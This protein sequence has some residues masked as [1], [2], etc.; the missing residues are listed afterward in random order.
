[1]PE[2]DVMDFSTL[3]TEV[4]TSL[5]AIKKDVLQT[6]ADERKTNE[7]LLK[8]KADGKAFSE[9]EEKLVKLEKAHDE[10]Q[11]AF[12]KE[13]TNLKISQSSGDGVDENEEVKHA[14]FEVLRLGNDRGLPDNQ[15]EKL[16]DVLTKHYNA[17]N[18]QH[19]SVEQIKAMLAGIDTTGG[20]LV[21]PP[22]LEKSIL[23]G[24]EENRALY[25]LASKTRISSPVYKRDARISEAGASWEGEPERV[26]PETSTPTYGQIE[27]AV[28][29]LI[30][31]PVVSR[32]LIEDARIDMEAEVM[33]FVRRA[34]DAK[35]GR[36]LIYGN[37]PRQPRGLLTYDTIAETKVKEDE[38]LFGK[39]GFVKTGNASG[40]DATA[41]IDAL[42]D[43]QTILK[44]GYGNRAAWLMNRKTGATIRKLK[45]TEGNYVWQP[46]LVNG[47]PA[48]IL[49]NPVYYDE[50]MPDI[51]ANAYP[52]AYGDFGEAMLVVNRRG[53][54]VIRDNISVDGHIMY[55]V[56]IRLGAGVQNFEA[57][58]L[59]KIAA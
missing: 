40:L 24:L 44:Q 48:A 41:P 46:S 22:F 55:K 10:A 34:F 29:K 9:L 12:D 11:K 15:K 52:I 5:D 31:K 13:I 23:T 8:A 56:D 19:K 25:R 38:M 45:D 16:A 14:F 3:A 6:L 51:A 7:E 18:D 59:L 43:L 32:D 2:N 1:M 49:G 58:K 21:V 28:K 42:I 39:L 54:T 27:I 37:T 26:W 4:K 17:C 47:Q 33:G 36:S 30:A 53:M 50:Y 20:F 35:I 57:V